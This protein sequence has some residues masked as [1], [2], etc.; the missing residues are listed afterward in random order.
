MTSKQ[1]RGP[2]TMEPLGEKSLWKSR[3]APT[4]PTL[5]RAI[6]G[7]VVQKTINILFN[8]FTY[9]I[10]GKVYHQQGGGPT[11]TR[12]AMAVGQV[13]MESV[14]DILRGH[15]L[16]SPKELEISLKDTILYIDDGR[17]FV[18]TM[19][20]GYRFKGDHFG[21]CARAYE[22]DKARNRDRDDITHT[23]VLKAQNSIRQSLKFTGEREEDFHDH[24][25]P[26]L[27]FKIRREGQNHFVYTFFEK[28]MRSP[29]ILLRMSAMCPVRQCI[30]QDAVRR[31]DKICDKRFE[32]DATDVLHHFN[33]NMIHSGYNLKE[34]LTTLED[35]ITKYFQLRAAEDIT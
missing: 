14:L 34:R 35:G 7:A 33:Q 31:L 24:F 22:E 4:D 3:G 2:N 28:G 16:N 1:I 25:I 21:Y 6:V 15:F 8:T 17:T 32:K 20:W 29:W 12:V 13:L 19:D 23:E 27:D 10:D 18:T 26:T 5:R 9:T 30:A 11:G